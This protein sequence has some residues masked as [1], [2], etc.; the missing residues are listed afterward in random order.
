MAQSSSI[1]PTVF[2]DTL[3]MIRREIDL[4]EETDRMLGDLATNYEG[5]LGA[6]L[7]DLIHSQES[8]EAFL[9]ECEESFRDSLIAQVGRTEHGFRESRS[10]TWD[11]V[12]R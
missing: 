1:V 6:A 4:D 3:G 10:T 2:G 8:I 12:K 9:D 7:S 5:N 11:E